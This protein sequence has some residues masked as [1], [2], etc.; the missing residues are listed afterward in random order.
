M[1]RRTRA[2]ALALVPALCLSLAACADND[3]ERAAAALKAEMMANAGMTTGKALDDEQTSCV[4]HGAVDELGVATLQDYRLLT[5]DLRAEESIEDVTLEPTDADTL[6]SVFTDCMDVEALMERQI[7]AGLDLPRPQ[8]RRAV[9]C[10]RDEVTAEQVTRIM[11]LEFQGQTD[12][13]NTAYTEL[14]DALTACL[15]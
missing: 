10:V 12:A 2:P 5:E 9:A 1:A 6:A 13:D 3:E 15:R 11:S 14:R 7:I 8:R 4:A